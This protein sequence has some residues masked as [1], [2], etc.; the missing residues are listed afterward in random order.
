MSYLSKLNP[1]QKEAVLHTE[2]PLLVFA[3][4]GSGKTRVLTYRVA[5]LIEQ[6]V[7][8]YHIIAITFTNKAAKEMRERIS[9]I[10][11]MGGQVWVSTFHAACTRI[12]RREID[13]LGYSS[14]FTI[15]DAQDSERLIKECIKE[16][17]L[18]DKD[19]PPRQVASVISTQ[20]NELISPKEYEKKTAGY[21]RD[22]MIAEVYDRYQ[23]K[24]KASNALDFDDIIFQTVVLLTHHEEIRRKYQNRF[25]YVMVDEY[26]DTNHAQY[27]LVSLLVGPSNNLCVVGDDDQSIY[28][29]RGA[30]IENILRFE[31]DYPQAKTVKLEENY[32]STQT[33]LSAANGVIANNETRA[34][35][36]LWTQNAQGVP[37]RLFNAAS[38]REEGAYVAN[39]IKEMINSS[40][41]NYSDFAVLYRTNA[42]SRIVEDQ[43]VMQGIPYRLFG[44]VRFYERMEIKDI[45]AY[46][47]AIHN[48]A[49]DLA[50]TRVIN[51]PR[52]GIGAA[53]ISKV[54]AYGGAN[55]LPF[56]KALAQT[57]NIPGL[58]NKNL[59]DF[60]DFMASCEE[61]VADNTV[62]ALLEKILAETGYYKSL[63]DGTIEG[64]SR[65]ENVD[66]LMAKAR[67]FE[68]ESDDPSLGRF[69]EDVALV[70]DI[71]NYQE[72]TEAISLMTLH[73]AK[74][75]EFNTV[76]LVGMEEFIFPSSRSIN[77]GSPT[78]LEEERRL[79]YVGF[80]RARKILYLSHAEKRMRYDGGFSSNPPSRFLREMPKESIEAVNLFGRPRQQVGRSFGKTEMSKPKP[81]E[82]VKLQVGRRFEDEMI[83]GFKRPSPVKAA[84]S[85]GEPPSYVVG[86]MV[87]VPLLG[88]GKV[89]SIEQ[90]RTDYEVTISFEATHKVRKFN[91]GFANIVKCDDIPF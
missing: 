83:G 49:D 47:K 7:D 31:K 86:D 14:G 76:F 41:A 16:L 39:S 53:T 45:L 74:G 70:A 56:S 19:F 57:D 91:T 82:K 36:A 68:R 21:Y 35:K 33:I 3:G 65:M 78:A 52:R 81:E 66:E 43:L 58:K 5:H 12:L 25:K 29:W 8:P 38:D 77:E 32:R 80:T 75:L 64:D 72:G 54:Q 48:P 11:P 27:R 62:T 2:G 73:S 61:F 22:S 71:D 40:D 44:G 18:N 59:K 10:T 17:Q 63:N 60:A 13:A 15:Y 37:I 69:L 87:K 6:G 20:K 4:A 1:A 84:T 46:L 28:G 79:C 88:V 85:S 9:S 30:D 67:E 90:K 51:V 24:L 42:Q 55:G 50:Y 23:N 26:Q 89:M 34:Q